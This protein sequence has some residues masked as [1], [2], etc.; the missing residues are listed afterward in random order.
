MLDIAA[1]RS[2]TEALMTSSQTFS[3]RLYDAASAEQATAA[4]GTSAPND[5]DVVDAEI[6]DEDEAGSAES[7]EVGS[8]AAPEAAGE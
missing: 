1:I 5:D 7:A 3:Q 8:D 2:A 4:G 6:V